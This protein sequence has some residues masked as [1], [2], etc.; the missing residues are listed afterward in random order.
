VKA[1]Y[2]YSSE[3]DTDAVKPNTPVSLVVHVSP[4]DTGSAR[5]SVPVVTVLVQTVERL[6]IVR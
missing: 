3:A 2:H 6:G 5:V 1:Y 4:A